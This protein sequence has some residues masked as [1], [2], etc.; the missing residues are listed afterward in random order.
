MG[1]LFQSLAGAIDTR[2]NSGQAATC[3]MAGVLAG[4]ERGLATGC[5]HAYGGGAAVRCETR[6]ETQT[7]RTQVKRSRKPMDCEE[8]PQCVT[9]Q[10]NLGRDRPYRAFAAYGSTLETGLFCC[11]EPW[12][13]ILTSRKVA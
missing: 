4:P 13:T 8:P 12:C 6:P 7:L 10:L 2:N 1:I 3:R 5:T 11:Y 9:C